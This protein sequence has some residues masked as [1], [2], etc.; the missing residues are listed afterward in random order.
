MQIRFYF[1]I[2]F[3][4]IIAFLLFLNNDLKNQIKEL[5]YKNTELNYE[6]KFCDTQRKSQNEL[7]DSF[8]L[9]E[10]PLELNRINEFDNLAFDN[11]TCQ[12]ELESL[13]NLLNRSFN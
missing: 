4:F 8:K 1:Y 3:I 11:Q 5:E 2:A 13:K 7:I 9:N 6:L 10:A 12:K